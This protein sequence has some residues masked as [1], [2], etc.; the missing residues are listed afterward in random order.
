MQRMMPTH[1]VA[2]ALLVGCE[3]AL[4]A[5]AA[6]LLAVLLPLAGAVLLLEGRRPASG[7]S[8]R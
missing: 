7:T 4:G 8:A 1:F 6:V 3:A 2:L 5:R